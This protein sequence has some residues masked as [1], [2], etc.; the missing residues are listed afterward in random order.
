MKK[1]LFLIIF[2]IGLQ[3]TFIHGM[4]HSKYELA[5]ITPDYTIFQLKKNKNRIKKNAVP[6]LCVLESAL[7]NKSHE[8]LLY[9]AK[10]NN[11]TIYYCQLLEHIKKEKSLSSDPSALEKFRNQIFLS[12][13]SK[14]LL[15]R[16]VKSGKT[17]K[18]KLHRGI[19]RNARQI[20]NQQ[21]ELN[22]LILQYLTQFI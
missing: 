3:T 8:E 14:L 18:I 10:K 17:D 7:R 6:M 11:N 9:T 22:P 15:L 2:C 20:F 1:N 13:Q 4:K 19:S 16:L 12:E 21:E 5:C